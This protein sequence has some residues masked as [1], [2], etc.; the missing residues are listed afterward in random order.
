MKFNGVMR[1]DTKVTGTASQYRVEWL[2]V[3]FFGD[4][5]DFAIVVDHSDALDM[6]TQ[7][8]KATFEL[9]ISAYLSVSTEP[10]IGALSVRHEE[11]VV[12]KKLVKLTKAMVHTSVNQRSVA[13]RRW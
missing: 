7:Q 8:S 1:D 5:L 13:V 12:S 11:L 10:Y 9:V 3:R 6:I 4:L 2:C